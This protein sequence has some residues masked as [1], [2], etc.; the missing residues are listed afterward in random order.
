MK[1]EA[2]I[3][4]LSELVDSYAP[5]L[6][7]LSKVT[8]ND[9]DIDVIIVDNDTGT[10]LCLEVKAYLSPST[11]R[12]AF[13]IDA[14]RSKDG[15]L[16]DGLLKGSSVQIPKILRHASKNSEYFLSRIKVFAH[17]VIQTASSF[18]GCA[19]GVDFRYRRGGWH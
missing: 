19:I 14:R 3:Q 15:R 1:H 2:L 10:Y 11:L 6:S 4:Q 8:L 16:K 9:T 12:E 18:R 5:R 13:D 17:G 7:F